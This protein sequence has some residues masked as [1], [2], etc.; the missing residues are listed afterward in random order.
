M[1]TI[2]MTKPMYADL[3]KHLRGN[4]EQAAFLLVDAFA[5]DTLTARDMRLIADHEF[6]IQTSF[7]IALGDAPRADLIRWAWEQDGCLVE[8]HSHGDKGPACFS[9]SD[10]HGFQQWVPHL[11]WRLGG[12]PYAAVV[13]AGDTFDGLVWRESAD[14]PAQLDRITF[15]EGEAFGSTGLTLAGVYGDRSGAGGVA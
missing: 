7:H 15:G 11:W 13:T 6:D 4:I 2:S 1:N 12:R 9:A 5:E 3:R 10:L 8:V 14:V